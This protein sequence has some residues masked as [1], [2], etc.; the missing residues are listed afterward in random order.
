VR[1][2]KNINSILTFILTLGLFFGS[3]GCD[4]GNTN[5]DSGLCDFQAGGGFSEFQ[6][7]ALQIELDN[8]KENHRALGVQAAFEQGS[9]LWFGE[10]GSADRN[11]T[12]PLNGCMQMRLFSITKTFT[13]VLALKLV[14][15]DILNLNTT[16]NTWYPDL[17][18][19]SEL[20]LMNL[21]SQTSGLPDYLYMSE[22]FLIPGKEWDH[23][24]AIAVVATKSPNFAPGDHFAYSN[25]NFLIVGRIIEH[26]MGEPYHELL[27]ELVL[28]PAGLQDAY[29]EGYEPDAGYLVQESTLT[30]EGNYDPE[31]FVKDDDGSFGIFHPSLTWAAGGLIINHEDVMKFGHALFKGNLL[32]TSSFITM[33]TPIILG[34]G[35]T[36]PYTLGLFRKNTSLGL[37]FSHMG[38][39]ECCGFHTWLGFYPDQDLIVVTLVNTGNVSASKIAGDLVEEWESW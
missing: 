5:R 14:E 34:D 18:N 24:E 27:R 33:T 20:T 9:K 36:S 11:Q 26:V 35:S 19:S 32:S 28:L 3:F 17:P 8:S 15:Q 6:E 1:Y 37:Y 13:T 22:I 25:T 12:T 30:P 31:N 39:G 4:D 16:V 10:T 2:K 7:K 21:L 23:D 38:G 29:I